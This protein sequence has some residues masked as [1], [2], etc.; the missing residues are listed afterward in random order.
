[1]NVEEV[2]T[3]LAGRRV[4][5]SVSGGKDSAA[6][7]LHLTSL[8]I[9]HERVFMD[10]GWEHPKT[11]E[12]LRGPLTKA[13]GPITEIRYERTVPCLCVDLPE[14]AECKACRGTRRLHGMAALV[15]TKAMFPSR[16]RRFC[17]T[18]LKVKPLYAYVNGQASNADCVNAV[19][20]RA[21]ESRARSELSEWEWSEGL[22]A[23]VW[24]PLI[25]WTE[26][27]VIAEHHKHGLP[28]NPL[29]LLGA[30]RVGCWPCIYARKDEIRLLA[31]IDPARVDEIRALET[32]VGLAQT[33]RRAEKGE[34]PAEQRPSFFGLWLHGEGTRACRP[35]DAVVKWSRTAGGGQNLALF[36]SGPP[37]EGCMRWGLCDTGGGAK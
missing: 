25:T 11:Y 5:A 20:V 34:P 37:D 19:G 29:Y 14:A 4:I 28:P 3:K 36:A 9:E 2:R 23:E 27:D 17:T 33:A 31:D 1:M 15:V 10:T 30:S 22:D 32:L 7:S 24:R 12:Y 13:L 6:M 18:E 21:Q 8:G 16:T 26:A 35:I